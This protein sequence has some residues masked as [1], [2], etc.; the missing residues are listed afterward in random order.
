[1]WFASLSVSG[2]P[3]LDMIVENQESGFP[4]WVNPWQ[5][6]SITSVFKRAWQ[7]SSHSDV[8]FYDQWNVIRVKLSIKALYRQQKS[9]V[10]CV[11][12]LYRWAVCMGPSVARTWKLEQT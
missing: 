1:M 12:W 4:S 11:L 7:N 8:K 5:L 2:F 3:C 6:L 9:M 10:A